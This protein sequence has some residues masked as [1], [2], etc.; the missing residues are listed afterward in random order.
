[1]GI[2]DASSENRV[3]AA[4]PIDPV[5]FYPSMVGRVRNLNLAHNYHGGYEVVSP[6]DMVVGCVSSLLSIQFTHLL[7]DHV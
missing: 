7:F 5:I 6:L 3:G 2:K 1:M 4:K